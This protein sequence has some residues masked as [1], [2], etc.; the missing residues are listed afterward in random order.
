MS[1][2]KRHYLSLI[3]PI[4]IWQL[5]LSYCN[6]WDYV[7]F[8]QTCRRALKLPIKEL[9]SCYSSHCSTYHAR[10]LD[11]EIISQLTDLLLFRY[12]DFTCKNFSFEIMTN[13]TS[14]SF[15]VGIQNIHEGQKIVNFHNFTRLQ[16]LDFCHIGNIQDLTCLRNLTKLKCSHSSIHSRNEILQM[17]QLVSLE[18]GH[19]DYITDLN[20]LQMLT[21]LLVPMNVKNC[22]IN[23]LT[24]LLE[25]NLL[26]N[27]FVDS[28]T[29][30]FKLTN[31]KTNHCF[32]NSSLRNLTNL[33]ELV[34]NSKIS[35]FN[36]FVSLTKLI[37]YAYDCNHNYLYD[38]SIRDLTNLIELEIDKVKI[39]KIGH[40]T[41]LKRLSLYAS[42]LDE[43]ELVHF[44]NL[45][46]LYIPNGNSLSVATY[47]KNLTKLKLNN[48]YYTKNDWLKLI[49]LKELYVRNVD[50]PLSCLTNLTKLESDMPQ[51]KTLTR[52]NISNSIVELVFLGHDFSILNNFPN[53]TGLE[54]RA[55]PNQSLLYHITKL[56]K[57]KIIKGLYERQ[58]DELLALTNLQKLQYKPFYAKEDKLTG[59]MH[60]EY[61]GL[62]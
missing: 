57:L 12:S 53:L 9:P 7:R 51:N 55:C 17:T 11:H 39:K 58:F 22:G 45:E 26:S 15:N 33:K 34:T 24:N 32:N 31:L 3:L 43:N 50:L 48:V 49:S 1:N 14:L 61:V 36:P 6:F 21:Y 18:I 60:V 13:L 19:C 30:L 4:E 38:D 16:E 42:D 8:R 27:R 62:S 35:N 56:N 23:K 52:I 37:L 20:N 29:N 5:I 10:K 54:I 59:K 28:I 44:K 46:S 41:N 2:N 25:L 47:L 40:L